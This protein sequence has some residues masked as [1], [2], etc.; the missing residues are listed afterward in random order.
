M[1]SHQTEQHGSTRRTPTGASHGRGMPRFRGRQ[2]LLEWF[3][4]RTER[5]G[6]TIR[7]PTHA[8]PHLAPVRRCGRRGQPNSGPMRQGRAVFTREVSPACGE[9]RPCEVTRGTS[10]SSWVWFLGGAAQRGGRDRGGGQW[11][12]RAAAS[13]GTAGPCSWW[14]ISWLYRRPAA[15]GSQGHGLPDRPSLRAD[16]RRIAVLYPGEAN[17]DAR[18]MPHTLRS[19]ELEDETIT[20][21]EML[22]G[23]RACCCAWRC[24]RSRSRRRWTQWPACASAD[25]S[26]TPSDTRATHSSDSRL[27]SNREDPHQRHSDNIH[28]HSRFAAHFF[29]EALLKN[30]TQGSRVHRWTPSGMANGRADC[31]GSP[32]PSDGRRRCTATCA[33]TAPSARPAQPPATGEG[34]GGRARGCA[35]DARGGEAVGFVVAGGRPRST[36][37]RQATAVSAGGRREVIAW[38]RRSCRGVRPERPGRARTRGRRGGAGSRRSRRSGATSRAASARRMR[39][40]ARS[41]GASHRPA[42]QR[43]QQGGGE[44]S[45]RGHA[46]RAVVQKVRGPR[47]FHRAHGVRGTRRVVHG[48]HG[49]QHGVMPGARLRGRTAQQISQPPLT[50]GLSPEG[51]GWTTA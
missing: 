43:G 1:V 18:V 37:C 21:L 17:T 46:A 34:V 45:G 7:R 28:K 44:H 40:A 10:A 6:V 51:P 38:V 24:R 48:A 16:V 11:S 22:V 36:G 4:F 15:R 8:C 19:V 5:Y 47:V 29:D 39:N 30:L 2:V 42:Q 12:W 33:P 27:R 35:A 23:L 41:P 32:G 25:S 49:R 3:K 50:S 9:Q 13:G 31:R 14:S 26:S 20:E